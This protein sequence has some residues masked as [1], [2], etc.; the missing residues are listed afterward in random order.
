M[1][2]IQSTF[3]HNSQENITLVDFPQY[4]GFKSFPCWDVVGVHENVAVSKGVA[5][6]VVQASG[7]PCACGTSVANEDSCHQSQLYICIATKY[8]M[9]STGFQKR[10]CRGENKRFSGGCATTM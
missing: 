1:Y 7:L 9:L 3:R 6:A 10:L 4:E 2:S 8:A 5:E